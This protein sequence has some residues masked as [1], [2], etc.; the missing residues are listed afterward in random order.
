MSKHTLQSKLDQLNLK[1]QQAQE[2]REA[3]LKEYYEVIAQ[4]LKVIEAH[5]LPSAILVGAVLDAIEKYQANDGII[6]KWEGMAHPFFRTK[7]PSRSQA[8][9]PKHRQHQPSAAS[10]RL[11]PS[12]HKKEPQYE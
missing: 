1:I 10:A 2:E 8:A 5:A 9:T 7:R 4:K 6:K 12:P 3:F 11:N